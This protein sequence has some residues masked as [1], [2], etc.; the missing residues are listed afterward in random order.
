V[1]KIWLTGQTVDDKEIRRTHM[2]CWI[3][4]A[5]NTYSDYVIILAFP[6]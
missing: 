4:K 1:G 3:N 2:A 6:R 5:I